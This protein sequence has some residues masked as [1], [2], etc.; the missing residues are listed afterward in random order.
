MQQIFHTPDLLVGGGSFKV[1]AI[2][3]GDHVRRNDGANSSVFCSP[4][5]LRQAF[6]EV[7][8]ARVRLCTAYVPKRTELIKTPRAPFRNSCLKCSMLLRELCT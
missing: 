8:A 1:R 5:F 2:F 3:S 7:G 4:V 6:S